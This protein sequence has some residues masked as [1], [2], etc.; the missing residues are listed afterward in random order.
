[1]SSLRAAAWVCA[2]ALAACGHEAQ[3]QPTVA[4]P[5]APSTASAP[6]AAASAD[7]SAKAGSVPAA[8]RGPFHMARRVDS[9]NLVLEDDGTFRWHIFGCDFGGGGNGV[10]KASG[11]GVVLLPAAG[12]ASFPW[13]NDVSYNHAAS[14]VTLEA[15][16]GGDL[17]A[18]ATGT[19]AGDAWSQ[20]W[21]PG[22]V[23]AQCGGGL[24]PDK[25]PRAC[26]QPVPPV[27]AP[28]GE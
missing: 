15:R 28:L 10:W 21:E 24:G 2:C 12:A 18:R 9:I 7:A 25:M 23:C 26:N 20:L 4:G 16:P 17:D 19:T 13:M 3:E 14:Q 8:M 11:A 27:S 22:R 5:T 6:S 1:M